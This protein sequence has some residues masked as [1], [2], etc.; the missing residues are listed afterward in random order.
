MPNTFRGEVINQ[1]MPIIAIA[2]ADSGSFTVSPY[3]SG[4]TIRSTSGNSGTVGVTPVDGFISNGVYMGS[5]VFKHAHANL[6]NGLDDFPVIVGD[7][8]ITITAPTTDIDG[9]AATTRVVYTFNGRNPTSKA[10]KNHTAHSTAM[11]TRIN[12]Y[13]DGAAKVY[14]GAFT[15]ENSRPG[16][17]ICTLRVR[18]YLQANQE[19][20]GETIVGVSPHEKS[21]VLIV[22]FVLLNASFTLPTSR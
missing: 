17:D 18:T 19:V 8:T 13:K 7:A 10:L 9:T 20:G 15:I 21:P 6:S 4:A 3:S 5:R 2:G 11:N 1:K 22:R 12:H 16:S 14:E